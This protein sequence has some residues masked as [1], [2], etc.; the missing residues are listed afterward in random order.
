M[1][2]Y[3]KCFW[4][5]EYMYC[6]LFPVQALN[7]RNALEE[8]LPFLRMRVVCWVWE[9]SGTRLTS[10][11]HLRKVLTKRRDR[12]GDPFAAP[13]P[14]LAI[15]LKFSTA[16]LLV[17]GGFGVVLPSQQAKPEELGLQRTI[18]Q[19]PAWARHKSERL[20]NFVLQKH[21]HAASTRKTK[22]V[23]RDRRKQ[24]FAIFCGNIEI[25]LRKPFPI[26]WRV[27]W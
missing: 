1:L 5:V 3:V 21:G 7:L 20:E 11:L 8:L 19:N 6:K 27:W 17:G 23:I 26:C 25:L 22:S 14:N 15:I 12:E 18:L 16:W 4:S 13:C 9:V 24:I 10:S 2:D